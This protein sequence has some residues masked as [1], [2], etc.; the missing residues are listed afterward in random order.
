MLRPLSPFIFIIL[1]LFTHTVAADTQ[2]PGVPLAHVYE[3]GV[4]LTDY[5]VSEKLDG[6][7]AYW[8]GTQLLSKQGHVYHAPAW[9]TAGFPDSPLDGE[10][11]ISRNN[12]QKLMQIVRDE[13]PGDGWREVRYMVFDL[14]MRDVIFSKRIARLEELMAAI[15]L[16]HLRRVKQFRVSDHAELMSWLDEVMASGGEGLMLHKGDS[17]YRAG[18]SDDLL[19]VKRY[20]DAEARVIAHLP[21]KGKYEGMLGALVVETEDGKRF[22]LGSGFTDD[23]RRE[24]PAVG[25]LVTYKY[26]GKTARG[27]PRIA[28]YMRIRQEP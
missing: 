28:S 12:Y 5:W 26:Y 18:R 15:D 19:K 20:Q 2:P 25:V 3:N 24:P 16:P 22:R 17:Y 14:P 23:E 13:T 27:I 4:S 8:D 10:L 9:F 1:I 7:R 6:V 11:W 21:G